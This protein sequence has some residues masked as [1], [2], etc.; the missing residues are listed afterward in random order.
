MKA[1][2]DKMPINLDSQFTT[3][4]IAKALGGGER[5]IL[6]NNMVVGKDMPELT[7]KWD[8]DG[9]NTTFMVRI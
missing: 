7:F 9:F 4:T 1:M 5:N 6:K 3:E 2:V 8:R